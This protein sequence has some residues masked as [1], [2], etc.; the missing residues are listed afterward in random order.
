MASKR[1]GGYRAPKNFDPNRGPR[2]KQSGGRRAAT[3]SNDTAASPAATPSTGG[4]KPPVPDTRAAERL[5]PLETPP[6]SR[7]RGERPPAA[8]DS[9]AIDGGLGLT[10][11]DLGLGQNIVRA[12]AELGAEQPYPIQAATIPDALAGHH[13]LGR[14]R[15][16]SGKTIAYAA[17]LV[18]RLLQLKAKGVFEPDPPRKPLQRGVQAARR[19]HA[20]ARKPKALILAPTRELVLQIDR[21]VQPIARAVGFYTAQLVGG[22]AYERQQHALSRGADIII[23]TPGRV[24]DL[25]NRGH[26]KLGQVAVTV[27]DEADHLAQLG[28]IDSVRAILRRTRRGGQRLL[29]SATLDSGADAIVRE[30]MPHPAVHEISLED[31]DEPG[32][33]AEGF[34]LPR[35]IEHR[36]YSVPHERKSEAIVDVV[37]GA[38]RTVVFCRTRDYVDMVADQLH[39]AGLTAVPLHGNMTQ[40]KRERH[41]EQFT[42]GRVDVLVATDVAAR[43]L[44]VDDIAL[45]LHADAASDAK[46]Y[47]HRAGRTGRGQGSSGVS[48]TLIAPTRPRRMRELFAELA[49]EPTIFGPYEF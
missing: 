21:T 18:E 43:G 38:G 36:V 20:T 19:P 9:A 47:V 29:F 41:L 39:A 1:G 16:G 44:H 14:G 13:I 4:L 27:I 33:G 42:S 3:S 30:F 11:H 25:E 8:A 15:T 5:A 24:K 34:D 49:I 6:Y 23:G 48:I 40:E 35:S 37:R 31:G 26:L 45:V 28:F 32:A 46:T 7:Q 22:H 17:A 10:F 12:L 2:R